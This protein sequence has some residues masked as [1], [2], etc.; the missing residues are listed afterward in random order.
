MDTILVFRAITQN[1]GDGIQGCASG[2]GAGGVT[3]VATSQNH[4]SLT[5]VQTRHKKSILYLG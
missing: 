4:P 1:I 2:V 5:I 3:V